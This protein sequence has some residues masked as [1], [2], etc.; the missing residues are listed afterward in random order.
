MWISNTLLPILLISLSAVHIIP[1]DAADNND[2][3]L[4]CYI[5]GSFSTF[6]DFSFDNPTPL[7]N[8]SC[9]DPSKGTVFYAYGFGGQNNGTSVET[10]LRAH[11]ASFN[12]ILV[13]WEKG[14]SDALGD[15]L[16]YPIAAQNAFYYGAEFARALIKLVA[17]GLDLLRIRL[18]GF[19]LGAHFMGEAGKKF[20]TSGQSIILIIGLDPAGPLFLIRGINPTC[21]VYVLVLHTNAGGMGIS[22]SRGTA[23]VWANCGTPQVQPACADAGGGIGFRT[24]ENMCSHNCSFFYYAEA[25]LYPKTHIASSAKSCKEFNAGNGGNLTMTLGAN[26]DTSLRGNFYYT[27][28]SAVPYGKGEAGANPN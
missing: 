22:Q 15:I 3:I 27:T 5:N 17:A 9:F 14:A 26:I 2:K 24:P 6:M 18:I 13:G 10:M 28:N 7:L 20:Q 1:I 11:A 16:G 21:A 12:F 23:D 8:S 25:L 19:S 4:R